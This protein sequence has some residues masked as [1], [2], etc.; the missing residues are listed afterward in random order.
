MDIVEGWTEPLDF[1]LWYN[2]TVKL[3]GTGMTPRAEA[4]DK[5]GVVIVLPGA[6]TWVNAALGQAR[7][8]PTGNEFTVAASPY[9]FRIRVMSAAGTLAWWPNG[10]ALALVVRK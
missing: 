7:Y 3:N 5:T 10:P 1:E 6:T 9:G 8:A 4:I 2:K